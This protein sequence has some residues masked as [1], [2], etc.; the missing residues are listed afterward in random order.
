MLKTALFQKI[1]F[2]GKKGKET[3]IHSSVQ[4]FNKSF[5]SGCRSRA[6]LVSVWGYSDEQRRKQLPSLPG[7]NLVAE[8]WQQTNKPYAVLD[9]DSAM[10]E[11]RAGEWRGVRGRK[12]ATPAD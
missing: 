5:W 1:E 12:G 7:H 10:E 8:D 2:S 3:D 11:I 9:G 6:G 4:L